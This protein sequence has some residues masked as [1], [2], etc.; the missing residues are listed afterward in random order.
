VTVLVQPV[1]AALLAY[2]IFGET[3]T[4]LQTVGAGLALVG[5]VV[6]QRGQLQTP[7]PAPV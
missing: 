7:S 1:A 2:L 4:C 3:L 5:I 6:A